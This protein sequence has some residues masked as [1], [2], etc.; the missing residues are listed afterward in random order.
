MNTLVSRKF[1]Q[2]LRNTIHYQEL[3]ID[4]SVVKK[5]LLSSQILAIYFS[6]TGIRSMAEFRTFFSSMMNEVKLLQNVIRN[7]LNLDTTYSS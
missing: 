5:N 4:L 6:N 7:I 2:K 3:T 1:A